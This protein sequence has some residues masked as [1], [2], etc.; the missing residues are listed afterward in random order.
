MYNLQ[1]QI[2]HKVEFIERYIPKNINVHL[3]GHSV[4]AKICLDLLKHKQFSE[5]VQH[6]YLMFPTIE[7]IGDSKNGLRVPTYD[8]FFFLF[9]I[10]YNIF[11]L[12]PTS[13]RRALVRWLCRRDGVPDK[14]IQPTM[15]YTNP[16][17][18]DRIWFMAL[19]EMEKIRDLDE[20]VIRSNLSRLKLYYGIRDDWVRDEAYAEIS[21]KFPGIDA[22]QCKQGYEHAFVLK[23]GPEVAKLVSQWIKEKKQKN[24]IVKS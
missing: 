7:R 17:V 18:I 10:F 20:D 9:R 15:Q 3:I 24:T 21:E 11:A 13:W 4:G 1:G 12:F 5:Q 14:F 2:K 19:D 16:R 6:L 8:R 22:E 23:T